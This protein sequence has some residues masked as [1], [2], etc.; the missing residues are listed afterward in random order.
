MKKINV[1]SGP[2][3]K[4]FL[5]RRS[6]PDILIW[7]ILHTYVD[8]A[9]IWHLSLFKFVWCWRWRSAKLSAV[10]ICKAKRKSCERTEPGKCDVNTGHLVRKCP[11]AY[12]SRRRFI[13]YISLV[14][15]IVM[16]SSVMVV[17][18]HR[19]WSPARCFPSARLFAMRGVLPHT[20]CSTACAAV[21]CRTDLVLTMTGLKMMMCTT[22][23]SDDVGDCPDLLQFARFE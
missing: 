20:W 10:S 19:P 6:Y 9:I 2:D 18:H 16:T 22:Y 5:F 13:E 12:P 11:A 23:K 4:I 3:I 15:V 7:H 1:I 8:I 14:T 21:S 17:R